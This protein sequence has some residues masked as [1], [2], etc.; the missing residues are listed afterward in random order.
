MNDIPKRVRQL[1]KTDPI[2]VATKLWGP[3]VSRSGRNYWLS[4]TRKGDTN[5]GFEVR[6]DGECFDGKTYKGDIISVWAEANQFGDPKREFRKITEAMAPILGIQ[7]R[8]VAPIDFEFPITEKPNRKKLDGW[9]VRKYGVPWEEFEK[10][11]CTV[12]KYKFDDVYAWAVKYPTIGVQGEG[13]KIR[14]L[15]RLDTR[16]DGKTKRLVR[17]IPGG[18]GVFPPSCLTGDS[19]PLVLTAGEEKALA[20]SL[21]GYR[22]LSYSCGEGPVSEKMCKYLVEH[23]NTDITIFFDGDFHGRQGADQT[24]ERLVKKGA[25]TVRIVNP[26]EGKDVNEILLSEDAESV[27]GYVESALLWKP[28]PEMADPEAVSEYARQVFSMVETTDTC[29]VRWP[30]RHWVIDGLIPRGVTLFFGLPKV[31]K[32][33]FVT[34]MLACMATGKPFLGF[35]VDQKKVLYIDGESDRQGF[36]E[37][38]GL[39]G[40]EKG[41]SGMYEFCPEDEWQFDKQGRTEVE[42][43]LEKHPEIKTIVID[44]LENLV[45]YPEKMDNGLNAQQR[46]VQRLKPIRKW[47][48]RVGVD[49]IIIHH[50]K[51]GRAEGDF[52]S[53]MAG[54]NGLR[55]TAETII[56]IE[57]DG[58]SEELFKLKSSSR[59]MPGLDITLERRKG[60][61]QWELYD[62]I[63]KEVV[64]GDQGGEIIE[65]LKENEFSTPAKIATGIG[66][67]RNKIKQACARMRKKGLLGC[68]QGGKYFLTLG[69][70]HDPDETGD[71]S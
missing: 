29:G 65:F 8:L 12:S 52:F 51:K 57:P 44:T 68:R 71:E 4:P 5:E 50:P 30:K 16:T 15:E 23:G 38:L 33:L 56:G 70:D 3:C 63:E 53:T 31:G 42:Q 20:L 26:P 18:S 67:D 24:A 1:V 6:G 48:A 36:A 32:T 2:G 41:V 49:I 47:S 69:A 25:K 58:D 59:Y 55:G 13:G 61:V 19:N 45:P 40:F 17:H 35:P 64:G 14:S 54:S 66:A 21:A 46:D 22:A 62:G 37:R 43:M 34:K 7:E 10:A 27:K 28:L 60:S 9:S 39:I 11:G